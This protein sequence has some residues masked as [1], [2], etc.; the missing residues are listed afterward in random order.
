MERRSRNTLIII[1]IIL[2]YVML[3]YAMLYYNYIFCIY[4]YYLLLA[5]R[6][7]NMPVYLRDGS[8][9]TISRADTAKIAAAHQTFYLTQSQYTDT[10][11]NSTSADPI[12]PDAWQG[13]HWSG[14]FEVTGMTR[15][16]KI[17]ASQ[18]GFKPRIFRSRERTP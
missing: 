10:G 3:C 2:C 15:P 5:Q 4:Y 16:G 13:S 9:K 1:I 18:A 11:P 14:N 7:S 17:P 12:T 6:P 8:A